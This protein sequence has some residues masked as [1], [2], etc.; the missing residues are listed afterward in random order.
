MERNIA[1]GVFR[2][3]WN[4]LSIGDYCKKC[5]GVLR[6]IQG[7]VDLMKHFGSSLDEKLEAVH[8]YNLFKFATVDENPQRLPCKV[9]ITL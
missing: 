9:S 4:S 3:N 8:N 2:L 5:I 6:N 7:L 1:P